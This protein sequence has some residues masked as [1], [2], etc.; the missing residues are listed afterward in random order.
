ML[1]V[2]QADDGRAVFSAFTGRPLWNVGGMDDSNWSSP[3]IARIE[4]HAMAFV[5]SYDGLLRA[6]PLDAE[7]RSA[8]EL[9][10]NLGFWLSFPLFLGPVAALAILLTRRDRRRQRRPS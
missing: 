9:R 7:E 6:L 5:G 1:H 3:A 4:G 8:P 10:S 2:N